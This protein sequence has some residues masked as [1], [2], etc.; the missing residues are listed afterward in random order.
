MVISRT[1]FS[2]EK[3]LKNGQYYSQNYFHFIHLK[4]SSQHMAVFHEKKNRIIQN[5]D[6][7]I[8]CLKVKSQ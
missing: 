7:D 4:G 1:A 2:K 5:I 8:V 3:K 6:N